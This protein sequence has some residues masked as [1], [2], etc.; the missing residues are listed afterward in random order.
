MKLSR[1]IGFVVLFSGILGSTAYATAALELVSGNNTLYVQDD[2]A[3]S[4]HGTACS[5]GGFSASGDTANPVTGFILLSAFNFNGWSISANQGGSNSPD[6]PASG[7]NGVGCLSNVLVE[8]HTTTTG[9]SLAVYFGDT[10]F[11]PVSRLTANFTASAVAGTA[12]QTAYAFTGALPLA[13]TLVDPAPLL[14]GQIGG[15]LSSTGTTTGVFSFGTPFSLVIQTL[16]VHT[17]SGIGNFSVNGNVTAVPEPAAL[18]LFGTVL[19]LCATGLRRKRK[20][21]AEK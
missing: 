7:S 20:L 18:A 4:C 5:A 8:A 19:A 12:T 14:L 13:P 16:F 17:G 15:S 2:G 9:G 1:M 11:S 3:Y 21:S 6:C 10:G